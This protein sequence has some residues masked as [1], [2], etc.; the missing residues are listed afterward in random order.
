MDKTK[1][2]VYP[3]TEYLKYKKARRRKIAA[4]LIS[5]VLIGAGLFLVILNLLA[6]VAFWLSK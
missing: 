3:S 4:Y 2:L 6:L 5:S 1:V